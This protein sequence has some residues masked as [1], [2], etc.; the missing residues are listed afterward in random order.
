[1]SSFTS[2]V[3]FIVLLNH[4]WPPG[5]KLRHF[6]CRLAGSPNTKPHSRAPAFS[7]KLSGAQAGRDDFFVGLELVGEIGNRYAERL[8]IV[9][10]AMTGALL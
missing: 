5:K 8:W 3:A 2:Q 6:F 9:A 7:V 4:N 10:G 1:M